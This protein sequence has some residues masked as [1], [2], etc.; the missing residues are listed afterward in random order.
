LD[1]NPK[2]TSAEEV[3]GSNPFQ[4]AA[5]THYAGTETRTAVK[6]P[7]LSNFEQTPG[8]IARNIDP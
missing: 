7:I 6:F 3:E 4:S 5:L 8:G 1:G 2:R